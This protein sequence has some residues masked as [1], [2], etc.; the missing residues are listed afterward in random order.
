[1]FES[2]QLLINSSFSLKALKIKITTQKLN[3][4]VGEPLTIIKSFA[5]DIQKID[6]KLHKSLNGS[7]GFTS[8]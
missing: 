6:T 8:T 5:N 1:M 7:H 2:L 4:V 3:K